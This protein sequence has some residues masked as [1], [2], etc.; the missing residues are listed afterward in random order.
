MSGIGNHSK[1]SALTVLIMV[2]STNYANCLD[3][4]K[5]LQVHT[6]HAHTHTQSGANATDKPGECGLGQKGK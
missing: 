5:G 6:P 2:V 1:L 4:C 3:A